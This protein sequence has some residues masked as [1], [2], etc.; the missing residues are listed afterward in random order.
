MLLVV[1][2]LLVASAGSTSAEGGWVLWTK[3]SNLWVDQENASSG[4]PVRTFPTKIE[5]LKQMED[6][7]SQVAAWMSGNGIH[8]SRDGNTL[9]LRITN[10]P[11]PPRLATVDYACV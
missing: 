9:N 5:C 8:V 7:M 1:W 11:D 6:V 2:L 3:S 10:P 4:K